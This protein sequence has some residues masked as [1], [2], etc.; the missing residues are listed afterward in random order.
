M[1]IDL[2]C[3]LE[4]RG[5]E[6]LKDDKGTT[7]AY[8]SL[9]NL[10]RETV[11]AYSAT[12]N[13][14]NALTRESVTEIITVDEMRVAPRSAF[15]LVHSMQRFADADHVELYFSS[16]SFLNG[17]TWTPRDGDIIEI[18]EQPT[19]SGEALD[20]LK[21]I[22]GDDCVQ[23]PQVQKRYWRCVCGRINL[24]D[25]ESCVRCERDRGDVLSRLNAKELG[26]GDGSRARREPIV[27]DEDDAYAR[28][29]DNRALKFVLIALVIILC[30]L[31]GYRLGKRDEP[32]APKPT[33]VPTETLEVMPAH[34]PD[35]SF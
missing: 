6:L 3:P 27:Y 20:R 21:S 15:K 24:L 26:K 16:V 32:D 18:G 13:W 14:Y 22:A 2:S 10:S 28:A 35:N 9:F 33:P 34:L 19:L 17:E 25:N 7:R 1:I 29:D 8:I 30:A 23:Y 31:I 4:L 5:Y 12:T 11:V